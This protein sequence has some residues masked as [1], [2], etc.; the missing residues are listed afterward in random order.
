MQSFVINQHKTFSKT[1]RFCN[2]QRYFFISLFLVFSASRDYSRQPTNLITC[3]AL[4][5]QLNTCV[6][7]LFKR[8]FC[9]RTC[10]DHAAYFHSFVSTSKCNN[11]PDIV[12]SGTNQI[13][14]AVLKK[15]VN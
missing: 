15:R 12:T 14:L 8:G 6:A 2:I 3:R 7:N 1:D 4:N 5:A 10:T 11:K 13:A 9:W